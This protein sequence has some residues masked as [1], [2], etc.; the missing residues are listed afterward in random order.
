ME[1]AQEDV[2]QNCRAVGATAAAAA[3]ATPLLSYLSIIHMCMYARCAAMC[4]N[5]FS[6]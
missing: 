5:V 6:Y 3:M 1:Q 2:S 4:M